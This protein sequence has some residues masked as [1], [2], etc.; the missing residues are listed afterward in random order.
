MKKKKKHIQMFDY[1]RDTRALRDLNGDR[2]FYTLGL[3]LRAMSSRSRAFRV[4]SAHA[5]VKWI[6][7]YVFVWSGSWWSKR[8]SRACKIWW[9]RCW[10][11]WQPSVVNV[12]VRQATWEIRSAA[13]ERMCSKYFL[14]VD[15]KQCVE[16]SG[17]KKKVNLKLIW[18][19]ELSVWANANV[20][21]G[22]TI[23][24]LCR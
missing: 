22:G 21:A 16:W 2:Y 23:I 19:N 4:H 15:I 13:M 3:D 10:S 7:Y 1:R 11:L 5:S 20:A 24:C 18:I 17:P 12:I 8:S 9:S 6:Y 14:G